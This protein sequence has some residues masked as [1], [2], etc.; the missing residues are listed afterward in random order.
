MDQQQ[1]A[2]LE[3]EV[4][5]YEQIHRR[6]VPVSTLGDFAGRHRIKLAYQ[7]DGQ[8]KPPAPHL[9]VELIKDLAGKCYR[10]LW[11]YGPHYCLTGENR[12]QFRTRAAAVAA[13][14]ELAASKGARFPEG[15]R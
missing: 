11:I 4:Q 10:L 5:E 13:G 14:V 9:A 8:L 12:A 3:T 15:S 6:D 2:A 7:D 1:V